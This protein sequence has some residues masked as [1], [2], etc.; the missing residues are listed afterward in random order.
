MID[1]CFRVLRPYIVFKGRVKRSEF[2][3]FYGLHLCLILFLIILFFFSF[4]NL[5]L[6]ELLLV[7]ILLLPYIPVVMGLAVS[8]RRL[9]DTGRSGLW[10]LIGFVNFLI[11]FVGIIILLVLMTLPSEEGENKYGVQPL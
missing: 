6:F 11:P 9:H 1:L 8:V 5:R 10:I 4:S 7:L 3:A 2:W